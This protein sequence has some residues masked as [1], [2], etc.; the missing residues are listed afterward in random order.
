LTVWIP[1]TRT[2]GKRLP[3]I[4]RRPTMLKARRLTEEELKDNDKRYEGC[5]MFEPRAFLDWAIDKK[6]HSRGCVQYNYDRLVLAFMLSNNWDE[7]SAVS[8]VDYNIEFNPK[9]PKMPTVYREPAD[10]DDSD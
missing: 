6:I 2:F 3:K 8:W 7:N 9:D 5:F 1:T 4:A 10:D